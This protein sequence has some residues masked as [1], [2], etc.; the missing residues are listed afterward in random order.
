MLLKNA[1]MHYDRDSLGRVNKHIDKR[2][3]ERLS[4]LLECSY[5]IIEGLEGIIEK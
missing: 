2:L 3:L 1:A 4:E 5:C